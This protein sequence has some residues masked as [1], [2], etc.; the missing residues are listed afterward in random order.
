M[1]EGVKTPREVALPSRT[2]LT[3]GHVLPDPSEMGSSLPYILSRYKPKAPVLEHSSFLGL[4]QQMSTEALPCARQD[5]PSWGGQRTRHL[6]SGSFQAAT[7]LTVP[8]CPV[9]H[10]A[11]CSSALFHEAACPGFAV[12]ERVLSLQP[13]VPLIW[14]WWAGCHPQESAKCGSC[15]MTSCPSPTWAVSQHPPQSQYPGF[16][17]PSNNSPIEHPMVHFHTCQLNTV[18]TVIYT[19]ILGLQSHLPG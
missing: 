3:G 13:Q 18:H 10:S 17:P 15:D 14:G 9:A 6:S 4:I 8:P 16:M 5:A 11:L 19:R 2:S 7:E 1:T 12:S